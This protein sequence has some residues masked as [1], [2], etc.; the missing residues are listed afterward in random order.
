MTERPF[1]VARIDEIPRIGN[2]WVPVRRHFDIGAFGVNAWVA[3]TAGDVIIE[4]H[5]EVTRGHEELY[6]VASGRATFLAE[7]KELDAPAGTILF[8]RDPTVR[9]GAVAQEAATTVLTIG[10]EPGAPY[11][12][13]AWEAIWPSYEAG[14]Y[15]RVVEMLE[16]VLERDP[17]NPFALYNLACMESLLGRGD[18]AVRHLR[19][20]LLRNPNLRHRIPHESDFEAIRD[21]PGFASAI[22]GEADTDGAGA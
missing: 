17:E 2:F 19:R 22:S 12:V 10:A 18:A 5:D 8:V 6:L 4:E 13:G 21:H 15:A 16:E 9:R 3:R 1:K 7:G 11:E 20:A 14:D